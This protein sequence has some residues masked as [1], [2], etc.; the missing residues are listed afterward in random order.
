MKP[1][2]NVNRLLIERM[3]LE[4]VPP[5]GG[6]DSAIKFLSS[7]DSIINGVRSAKKWVED[8]IQAVR[9]ASGPNPWRDASDEEIAGEILRQV[10]EKRR[11]K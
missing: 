3:S 7:K 1:G 10:E 5:G 6:I 2:P 4:A 9:L 8:A 11:K